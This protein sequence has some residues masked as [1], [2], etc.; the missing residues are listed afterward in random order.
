MLQGIAY[1][2]YSLLGEIE[3]DAAGRVAREVNNSYFRGE[4]YKVSVF[5]PNVHRY[6]VSGESGKGRT[7]HRGK[8]RRFKGVGG[9]DDALNNVRLCGVGGNLNVGTGHKF[10]ETA[11]VVRM[12]VGDDDTAYPI[13]G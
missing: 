10:R 5:K 13:Q 1:N 8:E 3:S 4:R 6:G 9:G 12:G 11:G 2:H 7:G